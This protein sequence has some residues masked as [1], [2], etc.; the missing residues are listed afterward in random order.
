MMFVG[1]TSVFAPRAQHDVFY[2]LAKRIC[3]HFGVHSLNEFANVTQE[4]TFAYGALFRACLIEHL[5]QETRRLADDLGSRSHKHND[6]FSTWGRVN[7]GVIMGYLWAKAEAELGLKPLAESTLRMKA[8][9]SLGGNKSGEAR[10]SKRAKTWEPHARELANAIREEQPSFSQDRVAS[11]IMARW[12]E[13]DF[14]PPGHKT[15]KS[16]ISQMERAGQLPTRVAS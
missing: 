7:D 3:N 16:L 2:K 11:E 14:E 5:T 1:V 8:G 9:G 15:L 13:A 12:K 6:A 10:R 4:N